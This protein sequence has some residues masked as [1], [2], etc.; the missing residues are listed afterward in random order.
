MTLT[1]DRPTIAL[2]EPVDDGTRREFLAGGAALALL[3]I[4]G[5][6]SDDDRPAADATRTIRHSKG[7]TQVP[8]NPERIV[9]LGGI[10][11]INLISLGLTPIGVGEGAVEQAAAVAPLLPDDVD[12]AGI[13]RIGDP[14]DPDLEKV[15]RLA[16]DL[17]IGD[18][19]Q[20]NYP[21]LSR[22]APTVLVEYGS[23]GTWR[24]RFL[25]VAEAVDRRERAAAVEARYEDVLAKLP[26]AARARA[27]AFVR[28][29][30][31]GPFLIDSGAAAF[32]GS[33]AKDARIS[34]LD[35]PRGIGE[36]AEGSGFVEVSGERMNVL[37]GADLI[38]VANFGEDGDG[39][40][41][42]ERN[43]LW[44]RLPAVKAGR[45]L[46]V[47]GL[48]YNGGN[49]YSATLLLEAIAK[50]KT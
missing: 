38:V 48:I 32:A 16:P 20:E 34:T 39:V 11:D 46:E 22:I 21:A 7:T 19:I 4:A 44:K 24:K 30:E 29:H 12:V 26:A 35:I 6:G 17:I 33:V 43:P 41:R 10:Y 40:Q 45:V 28:A 27:V 23:N 31:D 36:L 42:F 25:K 15:A 14:Y 49:H 13:E 9:T 37:E 18:D 50:A 47:H 1:L 2:L 3:G 8:A 5:C